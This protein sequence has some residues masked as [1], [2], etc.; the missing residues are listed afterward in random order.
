MDLKVQGSSAKVSTQMQKNLVLLALGVTI[1]AGVI[2][3]SKKYKK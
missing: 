1:G 2:Y 3:A